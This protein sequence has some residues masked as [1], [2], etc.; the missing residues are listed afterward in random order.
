M[1]T[2]ASDHHATCRHCGR[3]IN[4]RCYEDTPEMDAALES[5]IRAADEERD[6]LRAEVEKLRSAIE[7]AVGP[8]GRDAANAWWLRRGLRERA[9][10]VTE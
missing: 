6:E 10:M 5:G 7:W 8:G 1:T 9:G 2:P 4:V 3:G